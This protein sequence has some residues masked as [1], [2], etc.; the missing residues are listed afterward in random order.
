MSRPGGKKQFP[1]GLP[2]LL[3]LAGLLAVAVLCAL[4]AVTAC[5]AAPRH[6]PEPIALQQ[7]TLHAFEVYVR[8]PGKRNDDGLRTGTPDFWIDGLPAAD[9]QRAYAQ[10]LAG[11]LAYE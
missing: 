4:L 10:R 1:G 6:D 7:A 11:R 8:L 9:R 3:T 5:A 2:V